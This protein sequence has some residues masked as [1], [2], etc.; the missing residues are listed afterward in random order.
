MFIVITYGLDQDIVFTPSFYEKHYTKYLF[1]MPA[2]TQFQLELDMRSSLGYWVNIAK[3]KLKVIDYIYKQIRE[4]D[5][6][7][8]HL[9]PDENP[10]YSLGKRIQELWKLWTTSQSIEKSFYDYR[11]QEYLAIAEQ[12]KQLAPIYQQVLEAR[13]VSGLAI[14]QG[15]K[16]GQ[17]IR[18]MKLDLCVPIIEHYREVAYRFQT[19]DFVKDFKQE[20]AVRLA[21]NEKLL[22]AIELIKT[23][24]NYEDEVFLNLSQEIQ[25]TYDGWMRIFNAPRDN[26]WEVRQQYLETIKVIIPIIKTE[27]EKYNKSLL[28]AEE[29]KQRILQEV[30]SENQEERNAELELQQREQELAEEEK[31]RDQYYEEELHQQL[32]LIDQELDRQFNEAVTELEKRQKQEIDELTKQFAVPVNNQSPVEYLPVPIQS[33]AQ[34]FPMIIEQNNAPANQIQKFFQTTQTV[35]YSPYKDEE[36]NVLKIIWENIVKIVK[37]EK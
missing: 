32:L 7:Q 22:E 21:Y 28:D 23:A 18:F 37:R 15:C 2:N 36:L 16:Y 24:P 6:E 25:K 1:G 11:Y 29:E 9:F 19:G 5:A 3:Y 30:E 26:D 31:I 17:R 8:M 14:M 27:I 13:K 20:N 10:F 12:T 34:S 35:V 33:Q 4:L